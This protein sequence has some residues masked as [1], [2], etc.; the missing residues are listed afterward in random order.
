MPI[1]HV[2]ALQTGPYFLYIDLLS[3]NYKLVAKLYVLASLIVLI[4]FDNKGMD[5]LPLGRH[6]KSLAACQITPCRH[7]LGTAGTFTWNSR[8]RERL[9]KLACLASCPSFA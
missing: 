9:E 6:G 3:V 4:N 5:P 7:A 2:G 8:L 1:F